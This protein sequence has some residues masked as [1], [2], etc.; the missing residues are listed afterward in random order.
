MKYRALISVPIEADDDEH[1]LAASDWH[2]SVL[3]HPGSP[4]IA[5]HVELVTESHGMT[6]VR[7]VQE[8]PGFRRQIPESPRTRSDAIR[9]WAKTQGYKLT[10]RGPI[11]RKVVLEYEAAHR[12]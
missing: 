11:P 6:P 10:N 12:S 1:A 9:A 7:T 8:S 3:R 2:A 5:G 4:A